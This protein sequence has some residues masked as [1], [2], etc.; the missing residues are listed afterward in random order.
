MTYTTNYKY[1]RTRKNGPIWT[2]KNIICLRPLCIVGHG[3]T[4]RLCMS[5]ARSSRLKEQ[6]CCHS[7]EHRASAQALCPISPYDKKSARRVREKL[8]VSSR[9]DGLSGRLGRFREREF[10]AKKTPL[11][12]KASR[13]ICMRAIYT[14]CTI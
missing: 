13:E 10:F 6:L 5:D 2:A 8:L 3:P 4:D 12:A 14:L 9:P 7:K 1:S 11:Q